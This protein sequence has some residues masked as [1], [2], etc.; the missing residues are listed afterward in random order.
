MAPRRPGLAALLYKVFYIN[1]NQQYY[2]NQESDKRS[3]NHYS[4]TTY[5]GCALVIKMFIKGERTR[6]FEGGDRG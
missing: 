2:R 3:V 4:I 6:K 1:Q 5:R